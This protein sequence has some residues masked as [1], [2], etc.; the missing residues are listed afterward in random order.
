MEKR[1]GW[2]GMLVWV[3]FPIV[4]FFLYGA[5]LGSDEVY[6]FQHYL[7]AFFIFLS[8]V[9]SL[10]FWGSCLLKWLFQ[11]RVSGAPFLS[12]SFF[13]ALGTG[14]AFLAVGVT[15][16]GFLGLIGRPYFPFYVVLVL[17]S[18]ILWNFELYKEGA[19]LVEILLGGFKK[20]VQKSKEEF[21]SLLILFSFMIWRSFVSFL[22]HSHSDPALYHL[23]GPRF[24]YDHGVIAQNFDH[25]L[26]LTSGYWES[27]YLW[28]TH[29]FS[30]GVGEGLLI[31]QIAC[32]WGHY[33][34]GFGG[35][36]FLLYYLVKNKTGSAYL[37]AVSS[38][39]AVSS[40]SNFG[41]AWLAKNMWGLSFWILAGTAILFYQKD[42][43][44]EKSKYLLA[45]FLIG[46]GAFSKINLILSAGALL[47]WWMVSNQFKFRFRKSH[48]ITLGALI[49]YLPLFLRNFIFTSNPF[50]P[51]FNAIFPSEMFP[52]YYSEHT[53]MTHSEE[54]LLSVEY[55][56]MGFKRYVNENPMNTFAPLS[57]F[58][59]LFGFKSRI[60]K[61]GNLITLVVILTGLA[62]LFFTSMFGGTTEHFRYLGIILWLV[63]ILTICTFYD[64]VLMFRLEKKLKWVFSLSLSA[65]FLM[66]AHHVFRFPTSLLDGPPFQAAIRELSWT[67]D[68]LAWIRFN[69]PLG[70]KIASTG[71]LE[72]YYLDGYDFLVLN[73]SARLDRLTRT[74][75]T[76]K[77][78]I[79]VL[80]NEGFEYVINALTYSK[81][82]WRGTGQIF[83]DLGKEHKEIMVFE[84]RLSQV[85]D[86]RMADKLL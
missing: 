57:F 55:F 74:A 45:G 78:L 8:W 59:L 16:L 71:N 72:F 75:K 67:G 81:V 10:Y 80:R 44:E 63:P 23:T 1:K 6:P 19:G 41:T 86:L 35:V 43:R 39:F 62:G 58:V 50:F 52:L 53:S 3:L 5:P 13:V 28:L 22:P 64:L 83:Y 38:L 20:N 26:F 12:L 18:G 54:L 27:L 76:P 69:L 29:L 79:K 49:G 32:Q 2:I 7:G 84:G 15:L 37:A 66:Q 85:I 36:L 73:E 70:T 48:L 61:S 65:L 14:S 34:L 40:V 77:E 4:G 51:L 9:A 25:P 11:E 47:F 68:S 46:V 24:W 33:F 60:I 42:E 31:T 30:G 21:F 17:A 82:P 56:K